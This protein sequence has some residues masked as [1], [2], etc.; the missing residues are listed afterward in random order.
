MGVNEENRMKRKQY[1][2]LV[3]LLCVCLI[4]VAIAIGIGVKNSIEDLN[5]KDDIEELEMDHDEGIMEDDV[6]GEN[7]GQT[8][9]PNSDVGDATNEDQSQGDE[10]KKEPVTDTVE[11]PRIPLD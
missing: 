6:F 10:E 4:A 8:T 7:Q 11:L 9:I 1:T 5:P 2:V 3:I